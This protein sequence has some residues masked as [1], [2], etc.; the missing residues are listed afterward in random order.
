MQRKT[1]I[2]TKKIPTNVKTKNPVS[3]F[4]SNPFSF[5]RRGCLSITGN[6]VRRTLVPEL[7][8]TTRRLASDGVLEELFAAGLI[9]LERWGRK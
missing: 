4:K 7:V 6:Q 8:E 2:D 5:D 9:H 1:T 3:S